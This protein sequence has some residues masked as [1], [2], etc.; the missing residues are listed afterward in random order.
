[1]YISRLQYARVRGLKC[2]G[3]NRESIRRLVTI[4]ACTWIEIGRPSRR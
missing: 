3:G 2:W 1:M 4:C